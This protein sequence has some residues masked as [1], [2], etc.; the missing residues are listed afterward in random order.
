[1]KQTQLAL[2][3]KKTCHNVERGGNSQSG[4]VQSLGSTQLENNSSQS[5]TSSNFDIAL[6]GH[7]QPNF[8]LLSESNAFFEHVDVDANAE[9]HE[10]DTSDDEDN[11]DQCKLLIDWM[12]ILK[13]IELD[14]SEN[15]KNARAQMK[16]PHTSGTISFARKARM[17][18][19]ETGKLPSRSKIYVKYHRHKDGKPV[20]DVAEENLNK[21]QAIL[22]NQATDGGYPEKVM[23]LHH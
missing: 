5:Q 23:D 4:L 15:G 19:D 14:K 22:D 11:P 12:F 9:N 8:D 2:K 10:N 1:M 16:M 13:D 6:V 17:E 18:F 20:S 21:I 3:K 7:S